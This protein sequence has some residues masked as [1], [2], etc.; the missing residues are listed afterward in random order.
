MPK[1]V[2][3][4]IDDQSVSRLQLQTHSQTMDRRNNN[5]GRT[6]P[7]HYNVNASLQCAKYA[8]PFPGLLQCTLLLPFVMAISNCKVMQTLADTLVISSNSA[9]QSLFSLVSTVSNCTSFHS[10]LR[11]RRNIAQNLSYRLTLWVGSL[12]SLVAYYYTEKIT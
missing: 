3:W 8:F 9:H 4:T 2:Q 6:L 12:V 11:K 5:L 1:P 10:I 7:P